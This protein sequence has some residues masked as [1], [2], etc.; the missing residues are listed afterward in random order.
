MSLSFGL[1][2][3]TVRDHMDRDA[4]ETLKAVKAMGY[5]TVE[6]AGTAG[7]SPAELRQLLDE[8]GLRAFSA[9][10]GMDALAEDVDAEIDM[11]KTVG[12]DYLVI[13]WLGGGTTPDRTAWEQY[14]KEMDVA[15]EA[16]R[17]AGLKLCYHNHAHEF[18]VVDGETIFDIIFNTAAPENL[19]A[20]IDVYWV[21][22]AGYDPAEVIAQYADRCPI[23]H[24]KDM[25][26][27]PPHTF[28]EVGRGI[29]DWP[30][31]VDACKRAGVQ[32]YIVEQDICPEDSLESAR[33]SA[34][35]MATLS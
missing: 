8:Y 24:F 15:G 25:A 17:A 10:V 23:V 20:E 1:Q 19:A 35:F 16:V 7:L 27:T 14:A 31:M 34:E 9:H 13:P 32:W 4:G 21:K 6:L 30:A 12:A 29:M 11:A 18:E 22:H 33:I 28:T 2:L 26:A 5:D 3:Y